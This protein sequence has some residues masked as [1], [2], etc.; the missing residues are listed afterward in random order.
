MVT[1][2]SVSRSEAEDIVQEVF[3]RLYLQYKSGGEVDYPKTWLYKVASN[4]CI[5][6][7]GRRKQTKHIETVNELDLGVCESL[8]QKME[9]DEHTK[10]IQKALSTLKEQEKLMV[11][12]YSEGLS[13]KEIS[14]ISGVRF[15]SV[16]KSLSRALEKL[17][18]LLKKQYHEMLNQ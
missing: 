8:E 6:T 12:L 13:Y 3:I 11:I 7:V 14:V 5:N 17:K 2:F 1:K 4:I 18:P 15:T 16:S 9:E 10:I